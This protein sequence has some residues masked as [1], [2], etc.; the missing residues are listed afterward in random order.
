M[1]L[2]QDT[3]SLDTENFA[4]FSFPQSNDNINSQLP[5]VDDILPQA[6]PSDHRAATDFYT[7]ITNLLEG[8]QK[9]QENLSLVHNL[10]FV[11]VLEMNY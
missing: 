5:I 11:A 2:Y 10:L 8:L 4:N 6:P 3:S 7:A 9:F 1:A